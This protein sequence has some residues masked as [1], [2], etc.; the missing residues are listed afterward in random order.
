MKNSF[1]F[2]FLIVI[3]PSIYSISSI[4]SPSNNSIVTDLNQTIEVQTFHI[5]NISTF[6]N[7]NSSL[8]AYW[9]FESGSADL[10]DNG[11]NGQFFSGLSS[12]LGGVRGRRINCDGIND[13]FSTQDIDFG[14]G[15]KLSISLWVNPD[16]SNSG[17]R[18]I[19]SKNRYF[20][21]NPYLI[22]YSNS[23]NTYAFSVNGNIARSNTYL[24]NN[25][26]H[27]VGV[28][29]GTHAKIYLNSILED[30]AVV[31][32]IISNNDILGICASTDTPT[33]YP[34]RGSIDEIVIFDRDLSL[35]EIQ[36][37]YNSQIYPLSFNVFNLENN[38]LY[39]YDI[40]SINSSGF[41]LKENY[42]FFTNTSYTYPQI[43]VSSD[44][45]FFNIFSFLFFLCLF[46]LGF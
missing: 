45:P 29:N 1:F 38:S 13:L 3:L 35:N 34:F 43:L 17:D 18:F 46:F 37:L 24:P 25:W 6:I 8:V 5:S 10:S 22:S 26:N 9:N 30:I 28:F 20:S 12:S 31:P 21:L 36:S 15:N 27:V 32:S 14:P 42:N 23:T 2:V 19:V 16:A 41:L 40:F 44:F 33:Q 7:W 4:V 39:S 11:N